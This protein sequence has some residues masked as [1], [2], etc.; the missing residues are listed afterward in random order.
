MG[1]QLLGYAPIAVG[2][3][4]LVLFWIGMRLLWP[5]I[6]Q[7]GSNQQTIMQP[8]I[9]LGYA[10]IPGAEEGAIDSN[11]F[12][13]S[14][15][16]SS[17]DIITLGDSHTEGGFTS[18]PVQL[19]EKTGLHVYNMGIRGYGAPQ[20][21]YLLDKAF[22]FHPRTVIVG[23]FTGSGVFATYDVVYHNDFWASY[24]NP[25]FVD[26]HPLR[27]SGIEDTPQLNLRVAQDY[28]RA[29]SRLYKLAGQLVRSLRALVGL[30]AATVGTTNWA[31]SDSGAILRYEATP[32]QAT[33]F[34][35]AGNLRAV[36]L[37]DTNVVEGLRLSDALFREMAARARS[38]GVRLVVAVIPMK[39]TVYAPLVRQ[40][41]LHNPVFD[42]IVADDRAITDDIIAHCAQFLTCYSMAPF[43][44][45][46]LLAGEVLYP[47][48]IDSHPNFLG[49]GEYANAIINALKLRTIPPK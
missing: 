20:Y 49:F 9:H 44:Q 37:R 21:S 36:D 2:V 25:N 43:L 42:R 45:G 38:H 13:N 35:A 40:A 48:A 33:V 5:F 17:Y 28:I 4:A 22:S 18:W 6:P 39:E 11:G 34:D 24:R 26:D 3:L 23:L 19:A 30:P 41:G 7:G 47:D 32:E 29:H 16:K 31:T 12:R 27:T 1:R 14:S 15:V 10:F 8:D 46:K